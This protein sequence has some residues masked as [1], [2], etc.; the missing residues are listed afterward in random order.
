[1]EIEA[2]QFGGWQLTLWAG[3][4]C[5]YSIPFRAI[6]TEIVNVLRKGD[7]A[8]LKLPPFEDGE[9]FIEGIIRVREIELNIYYEYSLGYLALMNESREVL[10]H[11]F[12]E[13]EPTVELISPL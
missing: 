3:E 11:V 6:L 12:S 10:E 4:A 8:E 2:A 9:D 13:L 7:M 5:D 1:M